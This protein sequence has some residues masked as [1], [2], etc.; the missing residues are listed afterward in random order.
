MGP[1]GGAQRAERGRRTGLTG[2]ATST[3]RSI[4]VASTCQPIFFPLW[5]AEAGAAEG[6]AGH[7]SPPEKADL[8]ACP[9]PVPVLLAPQS[10]VHRPQPAT[11]RAERHVLELPLAPAAQS[12]PPP[13]PT[14][15]PIFQS[16]H[17]LAASAFSARASS[18][19]LFLPQLCLIAT[20]TATPL[21]AVGA[22]IP[23]VP[24]ANPLFIHV[25]TIV[26]LSKPLH[27]SFASC[28]SAGDSPGLGLIVS[29]KPPS[30]C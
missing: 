11:R 17:G 7:G 22:A 5:D 18:S 27:L 16:R 25:L 3:T 20:T 19:L 2:S 14:F 13:A 24:T 28:E 6:G 21:P 29:I 26:I 12:H 8:G 23:L 15:H 4:N 9:V 1:W 10:T 30:N